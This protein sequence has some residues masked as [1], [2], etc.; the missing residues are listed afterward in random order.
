MLEP[1]HRNDKAVAARGDGLDAGPAALDV[2][3]V[4]AEREDDLV[5]KTE[6]IAAAWGR[7]VDDNA[8]LA[9]KIA[10]SIARGTKTPRSLRRDRLSPAG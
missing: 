10:K 8:N 2:L 7:T 6:I 3:G 1:G 5:T 9:V 4:L